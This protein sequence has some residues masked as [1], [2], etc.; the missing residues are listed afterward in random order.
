M[1]Q[2]KEKAKERQRQHEFEKAKLAFKQEM[3][4]T[5]LTSEQRQEE[6]RERHK[7]DQE[8]LERQM[9][10][11]ESGYLFPP[12]QVQFS[13]SHRETGGKAADF[14]QMQEEAAQLI[15]VSRV[16]TDEAGPQSLGRGSGKAP[17]MP[18]FDEKRDFMDSYL[19]RFERFATCQR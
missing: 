9:Q 11:R 6:K 10:S 8:K 19:S 14:M 5:K 2:V 7:S 1:L 4:K 18:Y 12:S 13:V 15:D 16:S 3:K 17:K